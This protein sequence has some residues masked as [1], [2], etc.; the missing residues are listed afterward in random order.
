MR[1][2]AANSK[3][4]VS[5]VRRVWGNISASFCARALPGMRASSCPSSSTAPPKG[6]SC[7]AKV[8]SRVDLPAPFGP[9]SA[10]TCPLQRPARYPAQGQLCRSRWQGRWFQQSTSSHILPVA[11]QQQP[12]DHRR[13]EYSGDR[14]D[15]SSMGANK[16]RAIRSHSRQNAAPP[17]QHPGSTYSG[18]ALP[19]SCLTRCG[20]AMLQRKWA[21]QRR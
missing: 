6:A 21:R 13:A 12:N 4:V 14:A 20:T 17:K 11:A 5:S 7:P 9:M 18:R 3:Q 19:S 15:G 2:A 8:L 10:S 16:L 1:P